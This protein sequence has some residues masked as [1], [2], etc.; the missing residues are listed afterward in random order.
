[1]EGRE[2]DSSLSLYSISTSIPS[3]S[4]RNSRNHGHSRSHSPGKEHFGD[5]L[6][7]IKDGD[8]DLELADA[9]SPDRLPPVSFPSTP[10]QT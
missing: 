9:V 2:D 1:M 6:Q 4:R 7:E 5:R 8:G 10:I 3:L